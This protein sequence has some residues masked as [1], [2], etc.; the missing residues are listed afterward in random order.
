MTRALFAKRVAPHGVRPR[1]R[2]TAGRPAR[3]SRWRVP[4]QEA[5]EDRV[6]PSFSLGVAANQAILFEGGGVTNMLGI[7]NSTTNTRRALA[8]EAPGVSA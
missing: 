1:K 6:T 5:F 8:E 3:R 7:S 4:R 2:R